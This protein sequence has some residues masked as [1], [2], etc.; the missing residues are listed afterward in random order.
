M[1]THLNFGLIAGIV[2]SLKCSAR[3]A[4]AR[5]ARLAS[6]VS[7]ACAGF[8]PALLAA[9]VVADAPTDAVGNVPTVY[10]LD[11]EE[12][13]FEFFRME[14]ADGNQAEIIAPDEVTGRDGFAA[15]QGRHVQKLVWTQAAYRGTR[16]TRGVEGRST[17]A[18]PRVTRDGWY[19]LRFR[20]APDWPMEKR[21]FL[22]QMICWTAEFPRT[23]KTLALAYDGAGGLV[24]RGYFGDVEASDRYNSRPDN[25]V[26]LPLG[27]LE[28]GRWH[29]VVFQV[30][31]S[32]SGDGFARAW[33]D[34]KHDASRS[35]PPPPTVEAEGVKLG[36]GAW[37]SDT[38][39]R[40]GSY[41]KWGVY[42]HD[43][44]RY[45]P[46]EIRTLYYD[47]IAYLVGDAPD[48]WRQVWPGAAE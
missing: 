23:N 29:A 5:G 34:V 27:R 35:G 31:Y 33:L 24:L 44:A 48:A 3:R 11:F 25:T 45:T 39:M 10:R 6:L 13:L 12:P 2:S 7:F 42:A 20:V 41:Q 32:R 9:D 21:C 46:G 47:E 40:H 8:A 16:L 4:R 15:P 36:N 30:R 22:A 17:A 38:E 1:T 28:P 37:V 18:A 43:T 26:D 14:L 19:A